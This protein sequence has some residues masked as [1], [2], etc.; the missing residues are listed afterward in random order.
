MIM[1]TML[2]N[3]R[4][5]LRHIIFVQFTKSRLNQSCVFNEFI[6]LYKY[7]TRI[8][9]LLHCWYLH[10]IYSRGIKNKY[11]NAILFIE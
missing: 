5:T 2:H 6:K 1:R 4:I 10:D 3:I 11:E 8:I 7:N 9:N